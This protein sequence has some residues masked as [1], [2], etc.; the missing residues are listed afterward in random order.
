[1]SHNALLEYIRK[2]K[3]CGASDKEIADRLHAAGWYR[4]DIQD[5][6]ELYRTITKPEPAQECEPAPRPTLSERLVPHTYDSHIIAVAALSFAIGFIGYLL[7]V[8]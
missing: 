4:V 1:M 5:A 8:R 7:L 3:D 6:L 2:A